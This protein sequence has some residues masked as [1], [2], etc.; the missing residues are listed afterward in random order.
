MSEITMDV[1]VDGIVDGAVKLDDWVSNV[2]MVAVDLTMG[3]AAAAARD[4]MY[5]L[6]HDETDNPSNHGGLKIAISNADYLRDESGV[7]RI[8]VR[9]GFVMGETVDPLEEDQWGDR[10]H[11]HTP[12]PHDFTRENEEAASSRAIEYWENEMRPIL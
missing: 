8:V 1:T 6:A 2:F 9:R 3:E 7:Y 11:G 12:P 10:M 5:E 4:R